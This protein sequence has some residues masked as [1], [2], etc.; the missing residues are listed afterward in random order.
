LIAFLALIA[1]VHENLEPA[2]S[3]VSVQALVRIPKLDARDTRALEILADLMPREVEGYSR[4]DMLTITG[5]VPV[6]CVAEPDHLRI[7]ISVPPGNTKPALSLLD[8]LLRK[9][10]ISDANVREA[11][12]R[13]DRDPS[14]WG[15]ALRPTE[16]ELSQVRGID[17]LELYQRLVRP[18]AIEI[19]VG[20][21]LVPQEAQEEWARRVAQWGKPRDDRPNPYLPPTTL[22]TKNPAGITTVDLAAPTFAARDAGLPSRILALVA[23]GTGK[24]SS[25]FRIA[26]QK[27]GFSYRQEAVLTPTTE[28][29]EPRLMLAMRPAADEAAR[30]E[31]LRTALLEDVKAWGEPE[32]ARALGMAETVLLR[33]TELSPL[34]LLRQGPVPDDLEGRTFLRAYWP[35]KTG[36]P[37]DPGHLVETMR[38]IP[39]ADLKETATQIV[40]SARPRIQTG[41]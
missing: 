36:Q 32:R 20:G 33:S 4:R 16:I 31:T 27:L 23:L 28:G 10:R 21:R 39:L 8:A 3:E 15:A 25:L 5:G 13:R 35:M 14:Y 24:G 37:W 38:Q 30:A 7:A 2:A 34:S 6:H 1:A 19:A 18:D 41:R 26:R 12:V 29:W 22:R 17:V 11:V 9:S 40:A